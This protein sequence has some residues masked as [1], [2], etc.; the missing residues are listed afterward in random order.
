MPSPL[1]ARKLPQL[2]II[3]WLA[4]LP[5]LTSA[6]VRAQD[7][8]P[9]ED[10]IDAQAV[11]IPDKP[12]ADK[13]DK[14]LIRLNPDYDVWIDKENKQLILESYVCLRRG[15]LEMFACPRKTK[16]HESILT[17][18]TSAEAVHAALIALGAKPGNTVKY[19]PKYIPASG[20]EI[21]IE[22]SW[23]DSEGKTQTIRAQEW[24]KDTA[25]G[26]P[27]KHSWVFAGSGFW[28]DEMTG[29]LT[30]LANAGDFIC[31]SNFSSAMLDLPVKS[32]DMADVGLQ[33]E[34]MTEKIPA[35]GTPV[36]M[37]L[38]PKLPKEAPKPPA[39]NK[40]GDQKSN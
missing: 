36:T 38:I 23:K 3:C 12:A 10:P 25:T 17:T 2:L 4:L 29:K 28:K 22:L 27:M 19:D 32:T 18:R 16:E 11:P 33:F 15:Q 30:Y 6:L 26:K 1:Y 40:S 31:V 21:E 37:R 24:I 5:G 34:A 14:S 35:K 7:G 8:E 9:P 39:P 13:G 20:T